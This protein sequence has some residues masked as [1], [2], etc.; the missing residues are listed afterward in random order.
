MIAKTF[1]PKSG[2]RVFVIMKL[3]F[4]GGPAM[5]LLSNLTWEAA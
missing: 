1:T 4:C 2:V 3:S 5:L